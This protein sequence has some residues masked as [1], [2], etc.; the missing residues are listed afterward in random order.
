MAPI[1]E[2]LTCIPQNYVLFVHV[3][4]KNS[5][6]IDLSLLMPFHRNNGP[7]M[8]LLTTLM[9][10]LFTITDDYPDMAPTIL[11]EIQP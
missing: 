11:K 5:V 3:N 7:H 9:L 10:S 1:K 4:S 6:T 8:F 2:T